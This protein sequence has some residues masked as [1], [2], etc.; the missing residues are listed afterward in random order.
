M[1]KFFKILSVVALGSMLSGCFWGE[2]VQVPPAYEGKILTK[3]GYKPDT[4]P[5]ST[6]RLAPCWMPGSVCE[7]LILVNKSDVGKVEKFTLFMPKNQLTMSFDVRMTTY[8]KDGQTDSILN[9]ISPQITERGIK[10]VSFNK[11]Y[12]TYGKPI[13]RETVRS[14]LAEYTIDEIASSRDAVNQELQARLN[15]ALM[16]NPIGLKTIGLAHVA[17]PEVITKRKEQA[18]ERR[19][20]IE[21]EEA[22]KQVELIK[23]QTELEKAK[24]SRAIRREK[25]QAAAEENKIAASSITPE[26]LEYKKLEVLSEIA[27]SGGSVFIPFDALGSVGLSQRVF[28]GAK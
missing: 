10:Y 24:A 15:K 28:N 14:V 27:K 25:A 19:I 17:Y 1:K 13:L 8:I 26:Y 9:K 18:E 2:K 23:I 6:F 22:R 20:E 11:V 12:D 7:E 4:F 16:S 21:Q 5:P 3:N